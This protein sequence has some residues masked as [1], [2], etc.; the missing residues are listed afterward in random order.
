MYLSKITVENFRCFGEGDAAL[1]L[2][3]KRGL[4]ALV[5]ENDS[6]KTALIDAIRCVLGTTDQDGY[7]LEDSDFHGHQTARVITISC[8][9][10]ALTET[11]RRAFPEYLTYEG[12]KLD[13]VLYVT[14]TSK[15]SRETRKG[16]SYRRF[17][18]HSGR[19]G[20]G[21]PLVP[22]LR[23]LLRATYLRPLR[24]ADRA[25]SAGRGSRLSEILHQNESVREGGMIE[26]DQEVGD[27]SSGELANLSVLGIGDLTNILL[28]KQKGIMGARDDINSYLKGLSLTGERIS[29]DVK[30]G[31][32]GAPDEV[33]LRQLLEKLDVSLAGGGKLGL[34]SH[35]LLFMACELLLLARDEGGSKL[36]LIEEP[37]AHLH[38]QR[39]LRVMKYMQEAAAAQ[40]VQV[41]VT[42]HSPNLS[43]A[44][45]LEN[46]VMMRRTKAFAMASD[47]TM[48]GSSDYRFLQRFLDVTKA[49]L[50]FARAVAI[51]EGEAENIL[52]PAL[53]R[54]LGRN[55]MD[56][57]VS[58]VAVG[59]KGL[60][61]Y[62]R[63]FMRKQS[64]H[65]E[66]DEHLDIPVAAI[67]DLDVLPDCAP[68]IL[69][70]VSK[71]GEWPAKEG[72]RW[73]A[74]RDYKDLPAHR[75]ALAADL[76]AQSVKCFV[77]DAWTLE[78]CLALGPRG[79]DGGFDGGLA[80][81]VYVSA[82]LAEHDER[83]HKGSVKTADVVK[84]AEA[85]FV[86][87]K[88]HTVAT[89]GCASEEVLATKVFQK[90]V[91]PGVS[92]AVSAQYLAE[93]LEAKQSRGELTSELLRARMPSYLVDAIEHLTPGVGSSSSEARSA[94]RGHG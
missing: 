36:L 40:N 4:T 43:S 30:V 72:R 1:S 14:G 68:F 2:E 26:P 49:N 42:T 46:V 65:P 76:S 51:V 29:S 44:I 31:G 10:D 24:D 25:L 54:L 89:E 80:E 93:R 5:G 13:P 87:L 84:Q 27:M 62:A 90:F 83:I 28:G 47:K 86:L 78:Y 23:D 15:E 82:C 73:R 18:L 55:F 17:E 52:L 20:D 7:R 63:I 39:Q 66:N 77:A 32:S 79:K 71:G 50:F 59:G 11:D 92:K 75:A 48:L 35:N 91:R 16:R 60:G 64:A 19:K 58:V 57:G 56:H 38:A 22:E 53:A 33:R 37:E 81:E 70:M 34:G 9:F 74:N 69:E 45:A 3:L 12:E 6:G 94:S 85:A 61:R 67:V 88:K 8:R 21:P 41:I